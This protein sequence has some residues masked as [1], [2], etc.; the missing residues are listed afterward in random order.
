MRQ[1]L[2]CAAVL[3]LLVV[4]GCAPKKPAVAPTG[5][6][7]PDFIF[8]APIAAASDQA[9][10]QRDAW[11]AL[12]NGNIGAADK[13]L[14]R[15]LRRSPSDA[16]LIAGLGYVSLARH[17]L[18]QALTRFDQATTLKPAYA[19][20]L[21]GKGLALLEQGRAADAIGAF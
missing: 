3:A 1:A 6:Q 11:T 13:Q 12:Q 21:V 4:A 8:P 15:L 2:A 10:G 7:F 5:P 9:A 18:A 17:D 19:S 14:N 16:S 20:A